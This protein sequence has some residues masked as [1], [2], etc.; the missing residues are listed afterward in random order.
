MGVIETARRLGEEIQS[1]IRYINF[2]QAQL[3][4]EEDEGLQKSIIEFTRI[5]HEL[6]DELQSE[7]R[8]PGLAE[9]LKSDLKEVYAEIIKSE[10]MRAYNKAKQEYDEMRNEIN[11]IIT[12]CFN[13][14]DPQTCEANVALCDGSCAGCSGCN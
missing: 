9:Q 10:R 5:R 13:G 7:E 6:K 2:R 1:D 4:N 8:T 11:S 12:Q 14:M 3:S